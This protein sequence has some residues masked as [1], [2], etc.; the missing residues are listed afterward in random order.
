VGAGLA[1]LIAA[2][3]LQRSGVGVVM[4][5]KGR[6]VGGRLATRRIGGGVF[7][8]GAQF[9]TVRDAEFG[10]HVDE[11]LRA[12]VVREWCRGFAYGDGVLHADGHPRYCAPGGMTGIAKYLAADLDVCTGVRV[13]GVA[14]HDGGWDVTTDAGVSWRASS[15]LLTPPVPQSLALVESGGFMLDAGIKARLATISYD[16]CIAVMA[17]FA[18]AVTL[19]EPGAVQIE[20]GEPVY[21]IADN[22]RK[23]VSPRASA[24]TIQAGADFSRA[25]WEADDAVIVATLTGHAGK[26]L[27]DAGGQPLENAEVETWQV[28]RWRYSKPAATHAERFL[29]V[30]T[31]PLVFAGDAFGGPRVEGAALSGLAAAREIANLFA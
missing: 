13:E 1:G 21:W 18:G 20:G 10:K 23:G 31:P 12:G 28:K 22:N 7:D 2:R 29:A 11:W 4:L 24:L 26:F 27:R 9:F 14:A 19:P 3:E 17:T 8:H 5:D 30:R 25:N 6:G 16:P 15:L